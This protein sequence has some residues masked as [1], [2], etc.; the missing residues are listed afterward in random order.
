MTFV[1]IPYSLLFVSGRKNTNLNILICLHFLIG[2]AF[3]TCT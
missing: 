3:F 1:T 2:T